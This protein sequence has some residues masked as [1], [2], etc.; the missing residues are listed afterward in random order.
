[1]KLAKTNRDNSMHTDD[2]VTSG[3]GASV[4]GPAEPAEILKNN[5]AF[6]ETLNYISAVKV[7]LGPDNI[8]TI[9]TGKANNLKLKCGPAKSDVGVECQPLGR[10][11][12][13]NCNVFGDQAV[14]LLTGGRNTDLVEHGH[15]V[16]FETETKSFHGHN[17]VLIADL[18]IN[19][20]PQH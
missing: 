10:G 2:L 17:T 8:D 19:P 13:F 11:F 3:I 16:I 15:S 1:M 7:H 20:K 14:L 5:S 4:I 18:E 12:A 9:P 6:V